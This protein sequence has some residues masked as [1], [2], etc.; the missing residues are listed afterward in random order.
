MCLTLEEKIKVAIIRNTVLLDELSIVPK[1]FKPEVNH[2]RPLFICSSVA[3]AFAI[4]FLCY[5]HLNDS[6]NKIKTIRHL[7][8]IVLGKNLSYIEI[9]QTILH[10][11]VHVMK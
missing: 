7:E 6:E 5:H 1:D 10:F 2:R 9:S 8:K 3:Y 11:Y 4:K